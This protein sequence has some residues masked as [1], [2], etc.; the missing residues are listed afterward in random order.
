MPGIHFTA[1]LTTGVAAAVF[2]ILIYRLPFP[3]RRR[4]VWLAAGLALPLQPLA[5]YLIRVP[6]DHWL[7][8][9][10]VPTSAS[11]RWLTTFYAPVTEELAKLIPLLVP[12][13]YRDI[14]RENFVRYA[15]AI[16]VGFAIG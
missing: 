9:H 12:A 10:L 2:G 5:F 11:Y 15:L 16:G 6:M 3:A 8:A 1:A 14:R 7:A 13:I 4:F